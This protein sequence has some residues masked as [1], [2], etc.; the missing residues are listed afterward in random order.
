MSVMQNLRKKAK[1]L[2]NTRENYFILLTDGADKHEGAEC[3]KSRMRNWCSTHDGSYGFVVALSQT[4]KDALVTN[5]DDC[6]NM[7]VVGPIGTH[8]PMIGTHKNAPRKYGTDDF[9]N[10]ISFRCET[11][12]FLEWMSQAT[13]ARHCIASR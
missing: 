4:A 6:K 2:D 8:I 12:M 1:Y 3:V 5:L 9:M 13:T 7:V 11:A 10:V